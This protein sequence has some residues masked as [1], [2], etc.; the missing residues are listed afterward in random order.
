M[1][2]LAVVTKDKDSVDTGYAVLDTTGST[3]WSVICTAVCPPP[4][5]SNTK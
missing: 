4:V 1:Y 2:I 3:T 5:K